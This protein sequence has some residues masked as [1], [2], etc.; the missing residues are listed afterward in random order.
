MS[1]A[2]GLL[3]RTVGLSGLA[4]C[5]VGPDFVPPVSSV[6]TGF[7]ATSSKGDSALRVGSEPD[8]AWWDGFHDLELSKLMREAIS[9]NLDFR[10]AILRVIEAR[11]NIVTAR[12]AGLPSFNGTASYEREQLG[13]K[14]ILESQ[15]LNRQVAG[16]KNTDGRNQTINN[17]LNE[18]VQPFNLFQ[19]GLDASW[20]LDLFGRVRRSVE[21]AK[22]SAQAQAESANDSLV[23]LESQV[24]QSYA[25]LRG[26][27]ALVAAQR[28][29]I[30]SALMSL[31]L[32]ERRRR[33]GLASDLDLEQARTQLLDQ[34]RQLPP[35]FTQVQQAKNQLAVLTGR[36]PGALDAELSIPAP[37]SVHGG[38]V[39]VGLP[40]SLAR[41]R[42]DIRQA[43]ANLH[44]ATANTGVAVAMFYPDL[45]LSGD[46]GLRAIDV[47]YLTRWA[48][49]FYSGGPSLSLPIFQGGKLTGNLRLA[50]AQQVE[51]ALKYQ[52]TVLNAL[53]EVE[54]ALT[55]YRDDRQT[56]EDLHRTLDSAVLTL[57][58]SR[59]RYKNGLGDFLN[60]LN[61]EVTLSMARQNVAQSEV[62]LFE[63]LVTLYR[64]LGGG[65]Q[66]TE[67]AVPIPSIDPAPPP[68]PAALDSAAAS[69]ESREK[70]GSGLTADVR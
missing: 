51:M 26:A 7:Y 49:H 52:S 69:Q 4:A 29:S 32:T 3:L 66:Q 67:V 50:R 25:Q 36:S 14:G 40:T 68:V 35:Y 17:G 16:A 5:T 42:P 24:G 62:T 63:D 61:A 18:V 46:L 21:Q 11:Q 39:G 28:E 41:R 12:A 31:Q 20:E 19:Y 60:V 10:Q 47:S 70:A 9:G 15:G 64:A 37:L 8:P 22:A 30:Q 55:A 59:N 6:P 13:F 57:S 27:Q 1:S 34:Q 23:M 48:S 53:Q 38:F 65:W 33:D 45:S 58:L 56:A 2:L 54:N 43:E 44:A